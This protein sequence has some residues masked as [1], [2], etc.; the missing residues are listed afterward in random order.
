MTHTS[1]SADTPGRHLDVICS[2]YN[3]E[4]GVRELVDRVLEATR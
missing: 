2:I 1:S 3:D 4:R